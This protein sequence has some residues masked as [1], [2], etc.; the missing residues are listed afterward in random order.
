MAKGVGIIIKK[1][2]LV[3]AIVAILFLSGCTETKEKNLTTSNDNKPVTYSSD[4]KN[5]NSGNIDIYFKNGNVAKNATLNFVRWGGMWGPSFTSSFKFTDDLDSLKSEK[6]IPTNIGREFNTRVIK[7]IDFVEL[8]AK[9]LQTLDA[10]NTSSWYH[11][12]FGPEYVRKAKVTL[13]DGQIYE[14]IYILELGRYNATIEEGR[15]QDNGI[16]AIVFR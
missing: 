6:D 1:L 16:N 12:K 7:R 14:N 10:I 15:I 8:N 2:F 5:S 9:D 4:I 11:D 13:L 3:V